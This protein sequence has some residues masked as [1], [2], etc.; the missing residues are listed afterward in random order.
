MK[1]AWTTSTI[2]HSK[3]RLLSFMLMEF[4]ILDVFYFLL[5]KVK[6]VALKTVVLEEQI[7][8]FLVWTKN[9][10]LNAQYSFA[11]HILIKTQTKIILIKANKNAL[12]HRRS[13]ALNDLQF[14]WQRCV[15]KKFTGTFSVKSVKWTR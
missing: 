5:Q 6:N 10:Q 3:Q 13:N 11:V 4:H 15:E 14:W 9:S 8:K 2:K 12:A 1:R 7:V